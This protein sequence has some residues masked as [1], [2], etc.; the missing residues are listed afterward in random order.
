[1]IY[2]KSV[3]GVMIISGVT[4]LGGRGASFAVELD[5]LGLALVRMSWSL[6]DLTRSIWGI[7]QLL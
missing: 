4:Y 1:M 7:V 3:R 5:R 2:E 6:V